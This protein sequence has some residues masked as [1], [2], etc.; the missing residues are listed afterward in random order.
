MDRSRF[1]SASL[2]EPSLAARVHR[3]GI[4]VMC[5]LGAIDA[6][7]LRNWN[8]NPDGVSYVDLARAFAAHGPGAL[9]NGYWSP[10]YPGLLG[11]VIAIVKPSHAAMFGVVRTVGFGIF[12]CTTLAFAHLLRVAFG[13]PEFAA[14]PRRRLAAVVVAWELYAVF[15]L[16]A[17]SL[18]LVTPD[19]GVAGV[20]FW[21]AA[22]LITIAREP[23]S[24]RRWARLGAVLAVGYW[25]KA[26]L[27]PV[28]GVMLL[29]AFAVALRRRDNRHGPFA[30]AVAF[31]ALSLLLIVP[32]SR[33]T[34]RLTFGETGRL[35]HLWFVAGAPQIVEAC[36]ETPE[37]G[38]LTIRLAP[39]VSTVPLTC[40]LP[41]QWKESTLPMWYDPSWWYRDTSTPVRASATFTTFL[42]DLG[43]VREALADAA[44]WLSVSLLL[45]F[46]AALGARPPTAH[47]WPLVVVGAATVMSYLLVYVELRH[48]V[49]F[50]VIGA[51]A[52][53][54][55]LAA[56]P[57]RWAN[58]ALAVLALSGAID[59]ADH[60]G[61]P[62]LIE[63]SILRH[64]VRG[65]P[66]PQQGSEHLAA[67][68][69]AR[70]I[71]EGTRFATV[72]ALWN[73]DWAVRGGYV[74][75]AYTP[76]YTVPFTKT[77]RELRDPCA[78]AAWAARLADAGI[79][80]A[81]MLVPDPFRAPEG[82]DHLE[83]TDYYLMI[84]RPGTAATPAT[85]CASARPAT[86]SSS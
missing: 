48:I 67:L 29:V 82:F 18:F 26:I 54:A 27:F 3:V 40:T 69:H 43:F 46:V 73:L 71:E 42:R 45:V 62:L 12:V 64:E 51:V 15:V 86:R 22:E 33:E 65:D 78:R 77:F 57:S 47:T 84:I 59:L 8:V 37:G 34:G 53:L 70:G 38:R 61:E 16:K 75:R 74:V 58:V 4:A 10:L 85:G 52:A 23:V 20:V 31:A 21:T 68:L 14:H 2:S 56:R 32:V 81:L 83:D 66:R 63:A 39:V 80:A 49:P 79:G 19:I 41:D 60:V 17:I 9:I 6:A 50:I 30:S 35:N 13:Q 28:A 72:N 36:R 25:W 1:A 7:Y 24:T 11:S 55:A 44:P 76:E 5:T